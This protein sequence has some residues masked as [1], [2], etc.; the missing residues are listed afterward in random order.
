MAPKTYCHLASAC[1]S[2]APNSII[3]P[4]HPCAPATVP[5]SL[6]TPPEHCHSLS[7]LSFHSLCSLCLMHS[8]P[9][10]PSSSGYLLLTYL[11]A[12]QTSP[13]SGSLSSLWT[14]V[15]PWHQL[16]HGSP[17]TW[18]KVCFLVGLLQWATSS[19]WAGSIMFTTVL[20]APGREAAQ[21]WISQSN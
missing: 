9:L 19:F 13:L 6:Q 1:P 2:I 4:A 18:P 15:L 16:Y 17:L 14:G 10:H 21:Q 5:Y 7:P 11:T 12:V 8:S 3:P 20:L